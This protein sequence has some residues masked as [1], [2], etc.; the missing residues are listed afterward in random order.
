MNNPRYFCVAALIIAFGCG[1]PAVPNL[2]TPFP[3]H[4]KVTY[5]GKPAQNFRVTFHRTGEQQGPAFA[6]SA[7]TDA[8]GESRLQ[9]YCRGDGAPAGD[10]A[11]IFEWLHD[12]NTPDPADGPRYVD[13]LQGRFN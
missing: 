3:V 2:P 13:Q 9:S 5:A 1:K 8:P 6:P 10:Y 12:T 7:I 4:G 11:V